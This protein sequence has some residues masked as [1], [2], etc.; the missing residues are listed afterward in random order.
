MLTPLKLYRLSR[1][2]I[3]YY[4]VIGDISCIFVTG[5]IQYMIQ[6]YDSELLLIYNEHYGSV[7]VKD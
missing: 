1:F 6:S 2:V 3:N 5:G 4:M 7:Q